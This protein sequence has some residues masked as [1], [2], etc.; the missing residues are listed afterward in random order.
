VNVGGDIEV[1][2]EAPR[3]GRRGAIWAAVVGVLVFVAVFV[4]VAP[5]SCGTTLDAEGKRSLPICRSV[6]GIAYGGATVADYL[7]ALI[8]ASTAA[9]PAAFGASRAAARRRPSSN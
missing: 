6:T 4:L 5:S 9:V 2:S 1:Q 7:P 8:F 3:A